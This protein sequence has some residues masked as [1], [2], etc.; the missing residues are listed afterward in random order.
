MTKSTKQYQQF[1]S[2]VAPYTKS[3]KDDRSH[4]AF[5]NVIH[6]MEVADLQVIAESGRKMTSFESC[7]WSFFMEEYLAAYEAAKSI[8]AAERDFG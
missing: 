5:I 2:L 7:V 1:K 6:N 8:P 3:V 4:N